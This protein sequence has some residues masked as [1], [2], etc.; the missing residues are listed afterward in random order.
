MSGDHGGPQGIARSI[1]QAQREAT[2]I[3]QRLVPRVPLG[4][5]LGDEL[6]AA[7]TGEDAAAQDVHA[8]GG[9]AL[10]GEHPDEPGLG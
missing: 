4:D 2:H 1:R 10:R 7:A 6:I 5:R 8:A 3:G 9:A